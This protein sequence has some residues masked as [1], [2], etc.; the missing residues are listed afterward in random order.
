MTEIDEIASDFEFLDDWEQRYQYLTELGEAL[1]EMPEAEKIEANR[2]KACMSKVWVRAHWDAQ[3]ASKIVFNGD[4]D[5]AIIKGVVALL[6]QL[7]SGKTPAAILAMDVDGLF[8][9]LQLAENLSPNRHVGVYA[10]VDVM[11]GQV[12]SLKA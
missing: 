10:I 12:E 4:C 7:F 2:V 5:T 9:R 3:D 1:P 6:V 11:T 8:E